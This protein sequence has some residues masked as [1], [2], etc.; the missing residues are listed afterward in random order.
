MAEIVRHVTWQFPGRGRV[1][2]RVGV[3]LLQLND[4]IE[5]A[6][7]GGQAPPAELLHPILVAALPRDT[8]GRAEELH[9]AREYPWRV[10]THEGMS[11]ARDYR[12]RY[13]A[14]AEWRDVP[15]AGT[16]HVSCAEKLNQGLALWLGDLPALLAAVVRDYPPPRTQEYVLGVYDT[17]P[18]TDFAQPG[19]PSGLQEA[20]EAAA[21]MAV[22]AEGGDT[23]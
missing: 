2:G 5:V 20:V 21:A 3:R 18:A 1:G 14:S 22:L 19:T 4:R 17:T 11:C 12:L 7:L 8:W 23:P 15:T 6:Q 16:L 10:D 13:I 9:Q